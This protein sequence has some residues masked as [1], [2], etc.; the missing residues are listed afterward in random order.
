MDCEKSITLKLL[1]KQI[2]TL[3]SSNCGSWNTREGADVLRERGHNHR[4]TVRR[5]T[6]VEHAALASF[7][8]LQ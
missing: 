6:G 2:L 4:A 7:H 5:A 3:S 1:T 8:A